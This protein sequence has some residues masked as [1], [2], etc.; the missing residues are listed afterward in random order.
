[1]QTLSVHVVSHADEILFLDRVTDPE[2]LPRLLAIARD[3]ACDDAKHPRF[4]GP[5]PVSLDTSH[6]ASLRQQPYYVCE[7]TDGVRH[8][9]LCCT[10]PAPPEVAGRAT[11]NVCAL[12]DRSLKAYLLPLHGL[13]KA[14]YQGSLLDGEL[15]YNKALKRW[16]F[17]VFDAMCV[18]GVPVLN[19]PLPDRIDAVHRVLHVYTPVP[20]DPVLVSV[21]TFIPCRKLGDLDHHLDIAAKQYDI[22]GL[23][24]TPATTPVVYGRHMGMFK[25]K[26][27][28]TIDFLVGADGRSLSVF[29]NGAHVKVGSLGGAKAA[30][31]SVAECVLAKGTTWTLV[32]V[33]TDKATANDMFTYQKTLLNMRE[34]LGLADLRRVFV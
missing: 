7:K 2:A 24:L 30:P 10:L 5:N 16:E 17:L 33:R 15:A 1:M 3:L 32:M 20:E 28:H 23:I 8:A 12:I 25:L 14:M 31:G 4:P 18:S 19:C 9:M 22:D 6:F 21:K 13:P 27:K 11:I 26:T 29:D 34:K